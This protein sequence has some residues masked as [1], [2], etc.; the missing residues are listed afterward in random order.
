[1]A[2]GIDP[3]STRVVIVDDHTLGRRGLRAVLE[4][5][6]EITVVGDAGGTEEALR[7]VQRTRPAVVL[8]DVK[9]GPEGEAEGLAVC[10]RI[11]ERHP[12]TGV[13]VLST[14]LEQQ[15]VAEALQHG[16]R[17]YVLKDVEVNELVRI[18]G[19]VARGESG[20]DSRSAGVVRALAARIAPPSAQDEPGG[21]TERE[22]EVVGLVAEG[23]TN[24]E[25]G[26][27]IFVSESTVK[28]HVRNVMRKLGVHHRA[29]VAYVAGRLAG[30]A[31]RG[32]RRAAPLSEP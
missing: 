31:A 16:A 25:I 17:A 22:R 1:M 23:F 8:L 7:T 19:A 5:E 2:R 30:A 9:P 13:V 18:I 27:A 14:F 3:V 26:A 10:S 6:P 20:F 32:I 4:L 24:R 12:E 29:E 11:L 15:F 28:F 21:L